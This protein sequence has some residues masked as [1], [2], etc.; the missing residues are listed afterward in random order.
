M[1]MMVAEPEKV[2]WVALFVADITLFTVKMFIEL[3]VNCKLCY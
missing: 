2:T 3:S 1:H